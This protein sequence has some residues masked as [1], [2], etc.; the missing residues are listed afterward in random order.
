M[1]KAPWLLAGVMAISTLV[2]CSSDDVKKEEKAEKEIA[3]TVDSQKTIQEQIIKLKTTLSEVPV[4]HIKDSQRNSVLIETQLGVESPISSFFGNDIVL[5]EG[6]EVKVDYMVANQLPSNQEERIKQKYVKEVTGNNG[7][8]LMDETQT[9]IAW[10]RD[11][12]IVEL[13]PNKQVSIDT[14]VSWAD[15][16]KKNESLDEEVGKWFAFDKSTFIKD[17]PGENVKF[18]VGMTASNPEINQE[19]LM[20]NRM[21]A[22]IQTDIEGIEKYQI[23][24]M[25]MEKEAFDKNLLKS[26][27]EIKIGEKK[28]WFNKETKE[29]YWEDDK[30]IYHMQDN[31]LSVENVNF[32]DLEDYKKFASLK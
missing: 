9:H 30:Y 14:L 11:G 31:A 23:N 21:Y 16:F 17:I 20:P 32:F 10:E 15:S 7:T 22:I 29:L 2:G 12:W 8:Y 13:L 24:H 1:R 27:E 5:V 26:F 19:S 25:I 3:V 6:E 18:F 4:S 28:A